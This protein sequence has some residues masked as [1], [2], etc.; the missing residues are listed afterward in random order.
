ML[1]RFRIQYLE[2]P[3]CNSILKHTV[4][5]PFN[6]PSEQPASP[7]PEKKAALTLGRTR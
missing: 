6:H 3:D 1:G 2:T 4:L 5:D 7:T